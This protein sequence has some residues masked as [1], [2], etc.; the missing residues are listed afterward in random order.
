[1]INSYKLIVSIMSIG[2]G[3][4]C[5]YWIS[6]YQLGFIITKL[7]PFCPDPDGLMNRYG[8]SLGVMEIA[9]TQTLAP[10]VGQGN[11]GN[12][13]NY[14]CIKTIDFVSVNYRRPP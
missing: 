14:F 11:N 8:A 1:M 5:S 9:A 2:F 4:G 10:S 13:P 12:K 3:D 6:G 7:F